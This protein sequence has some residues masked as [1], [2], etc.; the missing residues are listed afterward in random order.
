MEPPIHTEYFLSGGAMILIFSALS[1]RSHCAQCAP[2]AL[3]AFAVRPSSSRCALTTADGVVVV[4][5]PPATF[6]IS[7]HSAAVCTMPKRR[8]RGRG[9]PSP[10]SPRS[11]SPVPS[12]P[13]P[14]PVPE[15]ADNCHEEDPPEESSSAAESASRDASHLPKA[16]KA[17]KMTDL[18]LAEE[19]AMAEWIQENECLY[20]KKMSSY[21][22]KQRKDKMWDDKAAEM[23]KTNEILPIWYR[24][25]RTRYGRL[26]K[27]KSGQGATELTERD[28]W[29]LTRFSFL[30]THIYEVQRRTVI[31]AAAAAAALGYAWDTEEAR[32]AGDDDVEE[33]Q[34]VQPSTAGTSDVPII[35]DLLLAGI[36]ER[37]QQSLDLQQQMLEML[38]PPV[39]VTQR[40]TYA[41]WTK[42]VMEDL[43]PSLWRRFQVDHTQ[44]LYRYLD[45]SDEINSAAAAQHAGVIQQQ[46]QAGY[47]ASHSPLS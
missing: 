3:C 1:M 21:K 25:L 6:R 37:G 24:S 12:E 10:S 4:S 43:D 42:S 30:K 34:P 23:G 13:A 9:R 14:E 47:S 2:T 7:L 35:L 16:K 22:D 27:K 17:K 15:P 40:T 28:Q 41:D 26:L 18:T 45:M 39:R 5:D 8:S 20:N 19:E 29:V 33:V 36:T 46:Q 44:L 31:K 38:K 32:E 11:S